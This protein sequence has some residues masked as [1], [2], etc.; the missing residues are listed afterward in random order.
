MN[1]NFQPELS[2]S[3]EI[4]KL[5]DTGAWAKQV[6]LFFLGLEMKQFVSPAAC[7]SN[8][9]HRYTLARP[10]HYPDNPSSNETGLHCLCNRQAAKQRKLVAAHCY[11]GTV[12]GW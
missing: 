7:G 1:I 10:C 8:P 12:C 2:K 4:F 5:A 3:L 6:E 11:L 9:E